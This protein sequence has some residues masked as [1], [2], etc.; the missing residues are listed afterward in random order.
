[1]TVVVVKKRFKDKFKPTV[2]YQP[3]EVVEF[4]DERA[5]NLIERELAVPLEPIK[6]DKSTDEQEQANGAGTNDKPMEQNDVTEV[7][8]I[9]GEGEKKKVT[10]Q[11]ADK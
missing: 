3:G 11:K 10:K 1:M 6:D 7:E 5:S 4:D 8:A 9:P 2:R